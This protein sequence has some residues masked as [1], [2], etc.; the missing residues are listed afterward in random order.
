MAV[1]TVKFKLDNGSFIDLTYNRSTGK[2]EGTTAA[3]SLSSYDQPEHK[4]GAT[5]QV[6]DDAGNVTTATRDSE[7]LGESLKLRVLEKVAPL[8]NVLSPASDAYVTEN[9]P[10]FTFQIKDEDSGLDIST[11]K[12]TLDSG[13]I[14]SGFSIGEP[15]SDG[16]R[17]VTYTP[18]QPLDDGQHS[19][20]VSV[21]DND[22]NVGSS[23][24]ILFTIDTVDPE[25]NISEPTDGFVTNADM[26]LVAGTTS[27]S[28]SNPVTVTINGESVEVGEGGVFSK[29]ITLTEG[30]N[31]IT[32][33]ATDAAG[34]TTTI[35]RTVTKDSSAPV[36][37]SI[38]LTPNP[39]DA[40][41][42][43]IITVEVE[44]K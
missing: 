1:S 14:I 17:T 7:L 4:Y 20:T 30:S 12:L 15:G 9:K 10:V 6:T 40:G 28:T 29:E 39:V 11:L 43:Y 19:Y 35:T 24:A 41:T 8:I 13:E 34:R 2:W 32:I 33:I 21:S 3:P 44:D 38:T 18:T 22:G 25:L 5:V 42:T 37:K 23:S 16:F 36:I 31:T 27:D 26:V